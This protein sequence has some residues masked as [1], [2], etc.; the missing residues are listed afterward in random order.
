MGNKQGFG[1]PVAASA[2]KHHVF[3]I[4]PRNPCSKPLPK[5]LWGQLQGL[6]QDAHWYSH[7][8][9][10]DMTD[11]S[12]R[13]HSF[14]QPAAASNLTWDVDGISNVSRLVFVRISHVEQLNVATGQ[15]GPQLWVGHRWCWSGHRS[16]LCQLN[17]LLQTITN[18]TLVGRLLGLWVQQRRQW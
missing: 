11:K 13:K 18:K 1:T 17:S 10:N 2:V 3:V 8:I 12:P 16:K 14:I 5:Q 6:V 9:T 15:H 4:F 7:T